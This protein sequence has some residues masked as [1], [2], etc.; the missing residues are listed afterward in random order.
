MTKRNKKEISGKKDKDKIKRK[1]RQKAHPQKEE[2]K[3]RRTQIRRKAKSFSSNI[4]IESDSSVLNKYESLNDKYI[5]N[6]SNTKKDKIE[7]LISHNIEQ[8]EIKKGKELGEELYEMITSLS[9]NNK[10]VNKPKLPFSKSLSDEKFMKLVNESIAYCESQKTLDEINEIKKKFEK[11]ITNI[12]ELFLKPRLIKDIMENCILSILVNPYNK[13]QINNNISCLSIKNIAF[14]P[15]LNIPFTYNSKNIDLNKETIKAEATSFVPLHFFHNNMKK[16]I[17]NYNL[18]KEELKIKIKNYID[19]YNIY[20]SDMKDDLQGFTIYTGDIFINIKYLK[21]YFQEKDENVK[22]IIREKI[23]LIIFHEL[24]N[25]LLCEIDVSKKSNFLN[26]SKVKENKKILKFKTI[27]NTGMY[28]LPINEPGNYFDFLF[29][30]KYYIEQLN[31][32]IAELYLNINKFQSIN[33]YLEELRKLLNE[34]DYNDEENIFEFKKNYFGKIP[35]CLF[36]LN[37]ISNGD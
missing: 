7:K 24:N 8:T 6:L 11:E 18:K 32:K 19:K 21:E 26:N 23:V 27:F 34:M 20:F 29:Y 35:Q 36:S 30:D 13:K 3:N 2:L 12:K 10:K 5:N 25:G 37:R 33:K 17:N 15:L 22:M 16:Y 1:L 31:T 28:Y 14:F 4:K 9:K